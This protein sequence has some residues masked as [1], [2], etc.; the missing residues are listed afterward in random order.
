MKSITPQTVQE[1]KVLQ[2][3][4]HFIPRHV[5]NRFLLYA[6]ECLRLPSRKKLR[7]RHLADNKSNLRKEQG[8]LNNQKSYRKIFYGKERF[9]Y[10]GCEVIA[11]YNALLGLGH[12][13]PLHE[14]I[15][16]FEKKGL[17]LQGSFGTSLLSVYRYLKRREES[18]SAN[19]RLLTKQGAILKALDSCDGM[20]FM[21]YNNQSDLSE[22]IHTIYIH[23]QKKETIKTYE[24]CNVELNGSPCGPF[25]TKKELLKALSIDTIGPI[26]GIT[27]YKR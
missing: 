16:Y 6:M 2:G 7:N 26:A 1:H 18:L 27:L 8:F 25:Q 12:P 9:S 14:L 17:L 19:V 22:M 15:Y 10:S 23:V 24:A 13:R 11:L 4:C 20:I 21:F 3:L 5:N